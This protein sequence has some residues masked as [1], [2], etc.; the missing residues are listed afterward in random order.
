MKRPTTAPVKNRMRN[1]Q[2]QWEAISSSCICSA[3]RKASRRISHLYDAM[4]A[5]TGLR[6]SQWNLLVQLACSGPTSIRDL[7][8]LL[9]VDASTLSRNL[10]PLRRDGLVRVDVTAQDA[11][12]RIACLTTEG[13][14]RIEQ[15]RKGWLRA[16]SEMQKG[17]GAGHLKQLRESLEI[18]WSMPGTQGDDRGRKTFPGE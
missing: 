13:R 6:A 5:D 1:E 12:A 7:A 8:A 11:R 15:A 14:A 9:V 17:L 18:V 3:L 2:Q 16:Q 4:L 10:A